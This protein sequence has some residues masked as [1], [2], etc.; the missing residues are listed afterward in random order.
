MAGKLRVYSG[1][2]CGLER[3]IVAATSK[4]AAAELI[5]T[6]LYD[7][8]NYYDETGNAEELAVALASPG[9]VFSQPYTDHR[10]PWVPV[11]PK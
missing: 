2:W 8:N 10:A 1:N 4:R 6:T 5:G 9:T 3:R 7:F 11:K